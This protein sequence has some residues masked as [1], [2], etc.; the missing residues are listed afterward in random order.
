MSDGI[1][2]PLEIKYL[3]LGDTERSTKT[4]LPMRSQPPGLDRDHLLTQVIPI[5]RAIL[6]CKSGM[7]LVDPELRRLADAQTNAAESKPADEW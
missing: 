4:P 1:D 3:C 2:E 5:V 6:R 7:T